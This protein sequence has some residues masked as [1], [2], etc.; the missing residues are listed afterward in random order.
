MGDKRT[1]PVLVGPFSGPVHGVS[2]INNALYAVMAQRGFAPVIIDLSPG[3]RARGPA[4]HAAR[5][6]RTALGMLRILGVRPAGPRRR[7]VMHLDGGGGLVYNI[8]LALALRLTGQRV[9]FYHHSSQYVMADSSLM[10]LLLAV[11]GGAPQ[12][13][14]SEKMAQLFFARYR[15]RGETL[16]INNAAWVAPV[17][18]VGR[19]DDG[20]LRLGFLSA[21][22]LEKGLG[23]AI[24]TLR[25]L[26][27]RG[28]AAE[29]ALAGAV[30]GPAARDLL[31]KAASEFGPA[32]IIRGVVQ[33]PD[34]DAFL[35]G[36]DYF[37]FPSLYPHETQ[38]LVVPEALSAGVPVIAH[39]HRFVGEVVGQGGLLVPADADFATRAADWIEG[40]QGEREERRARA[41]RQ[42]E[43]GRAEAGAQLDRLV[44]WS[45]GEA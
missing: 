9:L 14:C 36:L 34:K 45:V 25:T 30:S 40:G 43:T 8:A 42:F 15:L 20:R 13:F 41:R 32:L 11:A 17:P 1:L 5:I 27:G 16:V 6:G 10:R 29:L 12:L 2:V 4:Y 37:L 21:L 28:V 3:L 35:A 18:A 24:E 26:R 7:T 39:D 33:G 23:R 31:D 22:S 44:A 38:S 19:R